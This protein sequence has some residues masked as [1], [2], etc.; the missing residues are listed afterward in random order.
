M[1]LYAYNIFIIT[2]LYLAIF[3]LDTYK[4]IPI[5]D[6]P[7]LNVLIAFTGITSISYSG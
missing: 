6:N 3:C 2:C 7:I 4:D 1:P 5:K